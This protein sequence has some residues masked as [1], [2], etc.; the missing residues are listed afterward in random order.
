MAAFLLGALV[1]AI[2]AFVFAW[3]TRSSSPPSGDPQRDRRP[4]PDSLAALF[5]LRIGDIVQYL[6]ED[7]IVESKLTYNDDGFVWVEYLLQLSDRIAWLAVEEDD[8]IETCLL[9]PV[10]DLD[11]S[12]DPP[13]SLTYNGNTYELEES[14]RANMTRI[15]LTGQR[16]AERCRYYDYAGPNDQVLAIEDWD[17]Q[18]EVTV[19]Q[20]IPPRSLRILPG[21]GTSVYRQ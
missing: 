11:I 4:A 15:T 16:T 3:L 21:D 8:L 20:Q 1:V 9:Y 6:D 19:G 14:G 10:S 5:D 12:G 18:R 17:G 2:A 7:W 13:D